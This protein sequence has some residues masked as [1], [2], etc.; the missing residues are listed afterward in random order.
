L[1]FGKHQI[2]AQG[3]GKG[4]GLYKFLSGMFL[5]SGWQADALLGLYL[6]S[7]LIRCLALLSSSREE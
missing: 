6:E 1:E 7:N 3:G 5:F 4:R 2:S